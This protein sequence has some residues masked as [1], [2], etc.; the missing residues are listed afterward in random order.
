MA[1][2]RLILGLGRSPGEGNG[3]LVAWPGK[4]HGHRSLVGCSPWGCRESGTSEWLTLTYRFW[5]LCLCYHLSWGVFCFPLWSLHWSIFKN[6]ILFNIHVCVFPIFIPDI[7]FWFHFFVVRKDIVYNFYPLKFDE[8]CFMAW[9]VT[10]P[11]ELSICTWEYVFCSFLG[12]MSRSC[13]LSSTSNFRPLF[14]YWFSF[15]II[16]TL[17][18]GG[19]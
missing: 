18:E 2:P 6:S 3:N 7:D 15:W 1:D 13:I 8:I 17:M 11:G 16:F 10:C 4:S 5:K 9:N 19:C 12:G 14:P